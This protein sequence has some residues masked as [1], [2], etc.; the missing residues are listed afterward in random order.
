MRTGDGE[1][2]EANQRATTDRSAQPL[3]AP[4]VSCCVARTAYYRSLP[5]SNCQENDERDSER[6]TEQNNVLRFRRQSKRSL[7]RAADKEEQRVGRWREAYGEESGERLASATALQRA[8][9]END[10]TSFPV[11]RLILCWADMLCIARL[12][13]SPAFT[14]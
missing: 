4:L 10:T 8:S 1:R 2:G 5:H 7:E 12:C 13:A 9:Q 6:R 14:H 11:D 3:P